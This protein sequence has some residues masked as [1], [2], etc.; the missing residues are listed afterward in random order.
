MMFWYDH[1]LSAWGWVGMTLGMILSWGL[2]ITALVW[3]VRG[4][5]RADA[6]RRPEA[7]TPERILAERFARGEIDETEYRGRLSTLQGRESVGR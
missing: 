1:D 4:F 6:D 3:V 5:G 7:P 2:V